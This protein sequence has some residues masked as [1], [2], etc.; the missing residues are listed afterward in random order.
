ME[1]RISNLKNILAIPFY[2]IKYGFSAVFKF[3][4]ILQPESKTENM[5][6]NKHRS[7]VSPKKL[8]M[9]QVFNFKKVVPADK[10]V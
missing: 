4:K 9:A 2:I 8:T 10:A 6:Q 3:V 1:K 7:H 5:A